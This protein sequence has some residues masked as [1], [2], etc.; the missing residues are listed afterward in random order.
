[1]RSVLQHGRSLQV[2]PNHD[3]LLVWAV[4]DSLAESSRLQSSDV[5]NASYILTITI[6]LLSFCELKLANQAGSAD[7]H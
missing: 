6:G 5:A 7:R 2:S 3:E 4:G 1:M